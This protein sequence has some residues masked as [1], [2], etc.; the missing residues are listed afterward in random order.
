MFSLIDL[1]DSTITKCAF[2]V[3]DVRV[4]TTSMDKTCKF[5][6]MKS[7]VNTIT[8][9]A[10][11]N[12][13]ADMT[14]TE[15]GQLLATCGWDKVIHLWDITTGAYRSQGPKK[16]DKIH[17]GCISSVAFSKD[18]TFYYRRGNGYR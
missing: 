6:D 12:V 3:K 18:G 14:C 4:I 7:G 8:L 16:L 2:D 9:S 17:D 13:I 5:W 1:H 10:H 11:E 15:N